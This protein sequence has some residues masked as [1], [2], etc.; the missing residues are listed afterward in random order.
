MIHEHRT[1]TMN[2]GEINVAVLGTLPSPCR[3]HS[4]NARPATALLL[5]IDEHT[6]APAAKGRNTVAPLQ[7]R[8]APPAVLPSWHCACAWQQPCCDV[9]QALLLLPGPNV[10]AACG[11]AVLQASG[12][13]AGH[14]GQCTMRRDE[15]KT[16]QQDQQRCQ[17]ARLNG[18][19]C[20]D[21]DASRMCYSGP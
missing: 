6:W 16:Q 9:P 1:M 5:Q 3:Y 21:A 17:H 13:P 7:H 19:S 11:A 18:S 20:G 12:A 4:C 10:W 8:C 14:C 2:F 15:R